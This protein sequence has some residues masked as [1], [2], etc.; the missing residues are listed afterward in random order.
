MKIC[1]LTL[2]CVNVQ[3]FES[4][5]HNIHHKDKC[6]FNKKQTLLI[7][8]AYYFYRWRWY[9]TQQTFVM[10]EHV[11]VK[12]YNLFYYSTAIL[13]YDLFCQVDRRRFV[14]MTTLPRRADLKGRSIFKHERNN[15]DI[16]IGLSLEFNQQYCASAL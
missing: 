11:Y 9:K 5:V 7:L 6:V 16:W 13:L 2:I 12:V 1:C 15:G 14:P 10:C 8:P 4:T 3:P